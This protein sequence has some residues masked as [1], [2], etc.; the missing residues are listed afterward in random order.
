MSTAT[1]HTTSCQQPQIG[2]NF[3]NMSSEI[4]SDTALSGN[5]HRARDVTYAPKSS[6]RPQSPSYKANGMPKEAYDETSPP[7]AMPKE[8]YGETSTP[9]TRA[10]I[11]LYDPQTGDWK[12][13]LA[14]RHAQMMAEPRGAHQDRANRPETGSTNQETI[15]VQETNELSP[16]E[17]RRWNDTEHST[18]SPRPP[19]REAT[20]KENRAASLNSAEYQFNILDELEGH[21]LKDHYVDNPTPRGDSETEAKPYGWTPRIPHHRSTKGALSDITY[22]DTNSPNDGSFIARAVSR[23]YELEYNQV[24]L[25]DAIIHNIRREYPKEVVTPRKGV[26]FV[27]DDDWDTRDKNKN[28]KADVLTYLTD[29]FNRFV[30]RPGNKPPGHHRLPDVKTTTPIQLLPSTY[31]PSSPHEGSLGTHAT[32]QHGTDAQEDYIRAWVKTLE[33][34]LDAYEIKLAKQHN[35]VRAHTDTR[36]GH[37][38]HPIPD[39]PKLI[40]QGH[41]HNQAPGVHYEGL[42]PTSHGAWTASS[43]TALSVTV[44]TIQKPKTIDQPTITKVNDEERPFEEICDTLLTFLDQDDAMPSGTAIRT[45]KQPDWLQTIPTVPPGWTNDFTYSSPVKLWTDRDSLILSGCREED[46]D[47]NYF[48]MNRLKRSL[49]AMDDS[50][51]ETFGQAFERIQQEENLSVRRNDFIKHCKFAPNNAAQ[52]NHVNFTRH[53]QPKMIP[54]EPLNQ[55]GMAQPSVQFE[56][57]VQHLQGFVLTNPYTRDLQISLSDADDLES[58]RG[59]ASEKIE[60]HEAVFDIVTFLGDPSGEGTVK[61]ADPIDLT[62]ARQVEA[63]AAPYQQPGFGQVQV[64]NSMI[65]INGG[66]LHWLATGWRTPNQLWNTLN[67]NRAKVTADLLTQVFTR[68]LTRRSFSMLVH[69]TFA[70]DNFMQTVYSRQLDYPS[71]KKYAD[72]RHD[73]TSPLK[74]IQRQDPTQDLIANSVNP[75]GECKVKLQDQL[76]P[77]KPTQDSSCGSLT[78]NFID[79]TLDSSS[80]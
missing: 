36:A 57:A 3:Y 17:F 39:N 16:D 75:R 44:S 80:R 78:Q 32:L 74:E 8:A 68:V 30:W 47:P 73:W 40:D 63:M 70:D 14:L 20:L 24:S 66:S 56:L 79:L 60:A 77:S 29:H 37:N 51:T 55:Y 1:E 58:K 26:H 45:E 12:S 41:E 4:P 64:E 59:A 50:S 9:I 76:D 5:V 54:S 15:P 23:I 18:N 21:G 10:V 53:S 35:T 11:P 42:I 49:S 62:G 48:D 34:R 28:T 67:A 25:A 6:K 33:A 2:F 46:D 52:V 71:N 38:E 72:P 61:P 19:D 27:R 69:L 31:I 13:P 7:N 43:E 22:F 65:Y